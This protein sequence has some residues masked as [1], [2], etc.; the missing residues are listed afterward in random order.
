MKNLKE[1]PNG[2]FWG[3][4][5]AANQFEGAWNVDGKGVSISD[6]MTSGTHKEPRRITPSIDEDKYYYPSHEAV[7]F[8]HHYKEDIAL[9]AEM[10][11]NIFRMS[12]NWTRIFPN[13]NE[14]EPNEAGLKFYDNVFNELKKYNIEPLVTIYH[15]ENPLSLTFECN[16][17]SDRKCIDYYLN[18]CEV[19]FKRYKDVVKYWIPFNEINCLTTKLGNWNHAGILHEGTE[20]FTSQGDD[21]NMRFAALHHQFVASAKAVLLGKQINPEFKFGTM[22]C[23]I[24]VYPLTCNPDDV[25]L[26]QQEDL[27]RNCFSGDVQVKGIYPYYIKHYFEQNNIHFDITDEDLEIIKKG[28]VDFYSF[29]Y[30]MSNCITANKDA[31]QVSGNIMGGA[32][33]PYLTATEWD[34]QIDPKGLRYTLNHVYDRYGVPVMVTENGLGA[35]DTLTEDGKIHDDYRIDYIK[36]HIEQ[37]RLAIDDGVELIGYTPWATIDL[38]SV[39]TGEMEKR[40]GFIYVDKDNDGNGT[41]DRYR[42]DSFEWYK[43]VISSN[44]NDLD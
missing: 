26:T 3:G 39:S 33:N 14:S 42:K 22:I 2:F 24:T 40:Y 11:F 4:A 10:G 13:G 8:Y 1:F 17:W 9:C 43:K 37:M 38:V 19:L 25:I 20:F 12:I 21:P 28:V 30:Y 6:I 15:N 16:G 31:A 7:D 36:K 23:H 34:W 29:S 35:R 27:M 44:G 18:F 32:K 41:L 5:T